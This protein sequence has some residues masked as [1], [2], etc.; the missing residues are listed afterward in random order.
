M[1]FLGSILKI[2]LF[3]LFVK[4]TPVSSC[5]LLIFKTVL[6]NNITSLGDGQ[7]T[8]RMQVCLGKTSFSPLHDPL[9]SREARGSAILGH[10]LASFAY[11]TKANY[12]FFQS[13]VQQYIR[14]NLVCWMGA[15]KRTQTI[16][17]WVI[18][19]KSF[20]QLCFLMFKGGIFW[21]SVCADGGVCSF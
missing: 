21:G 8:V 7:Q 17:H 11:H 15:K 6:C 10:K 14:N 20:Q 2:L 13:W 3:K 5:Q 16:S 1:N 19:F 18:L 12:F 4:S 9:S